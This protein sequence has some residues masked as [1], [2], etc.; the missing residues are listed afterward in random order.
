MRRCDCVTVAGGRWRAVVEQSEHSEQSGWPLRDDRQALAM[1]RST[2]REAR[3]TWA[4]RLALAHHRESVAMLH[5]AARSQ[6][7]ST[8]ASVQPIRHR[9]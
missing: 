4:P 3:S 6:Q 5:D 2:K 1:R 7:I 9:L 8:S